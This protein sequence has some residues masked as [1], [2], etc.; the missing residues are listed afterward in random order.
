MACLGVL[1]EQFLDF[2]PRAFQLAIQAYNKQQEQHNKL[3]L[4]AARLSGYLA[5]RP[6]M[7]ME[8]QQQYWCPQLYYKLPWEK[9]L[10]KQTKPA[11]TDQDLEKAR[12]WLNSN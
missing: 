4:E 5:A 12:K 11:P 6:V 7:S 1:P 8:A 3:S 2:T 9:D 10:P